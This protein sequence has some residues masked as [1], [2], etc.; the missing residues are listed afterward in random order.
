MKINHKHIAKFSS[1]ILYIFNFF[2]YFFNF[3][4]N[5]IRVL[6]YHHI[7]S[8]KFKDF[9]DQLYFIKK[10]WKFITPKQFEDHINGKIKLKGKNVLL[11]FDDGFISNF[12]IEKKILNKLNIKCIFFVPS[13]FISIKKINDAQNFVKKNILDQN[14]PSDFKKVK[15]MTIKNLKKLIHNGHTIGSHTKNHVNLGSIYDNKILKNELIESA[16]DLEKKLNTK[17]KHFAFTY[18]NYESM[19]EKSLKL[20]FKKYDYVYSGL[21][22]GN[23]RNKKNQI[24][25]RDAVYLKY[26]NNL[27]SIFINGIIDLK[28]FFQIL[29]INKK[30][31][32]IKNKYEFK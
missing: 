11:S 4:S 31:N 26:G 2:N 21:R 24:I 1:L 30:I 25:K 32:K 10:K 5:E 27:L 3:K 13:N 12:E 22:G 6:V 16:T 7:E 28:Y 19:N 20:A 14:F 23:Y 9:R 15:N 29:S 17:I 18:G 8:T